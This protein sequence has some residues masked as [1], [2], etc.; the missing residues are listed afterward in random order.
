MWWLLWTAVGIA[1]FCLIV[2]GFWLIALLH[3]RKG[4]EAMK[5]FEEVVFAHRGLHDDKRP[6]NSMAAFAAAAEKGYGIE[7]DLHLTRDGVLVVN[8]DGTTKR[9][10]GTDLKIN[11]CTLEEL[12]AVSLPD[13]SKI[14]TFREFLELVDGRS[15]LLIELKNDGNSGRALVDCML[16]ELEGYKGKYIVESFDPRVLVALK[17]AAP[18]VARGQLCQDFLRTKD[19]PGYMRLLLWSMFMNLFTYPDFVAYNT[20]HRSAL[21]L[22]LLRR[23]GCRICFWTVRDQEDFDRCVKDGTNPIFERFIPKR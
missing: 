19:A 18:D 21:P 7:F 3:T 4:G 1:A 8:H 2:A 13:G 12:R 16:K 20:A 5:G 14:P 23:A 6:E 11:A 17:K 9:M 22:R 10:C 15:P